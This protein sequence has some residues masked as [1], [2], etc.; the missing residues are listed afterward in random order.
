[1]I[2]KVKAII[3]AVLTFI[4]FYG[5]PETINQITRA[6]G[7]TLTIFN[8]MWFIMIGIIVSVLVFFNIF[9]SKTHPGISGV[10][11]ILKNIVEA[12]YVYTTINMFSVIELSENM[13]ISINFALLQLL[14][15]INLGLWILYNLYITMHRKELAEKKKEEIKA[16]KEVSLEEIEVEKTSSK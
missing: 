8:R 6:Y 2:E 4:G 15:L 11:G 13:R 5:L 9:F 1:M 12:Y 3:N 16:I 10:A 14:I 7:V